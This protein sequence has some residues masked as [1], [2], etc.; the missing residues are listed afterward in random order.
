MVAVFVI[1]IELT[2][3]L[4]NKPAALAHIFKMNAVLL[5]LAKSTP[6]PTWSA[7]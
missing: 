7:A 6:S 5:V 3:V 4:R 2:Y 1:Y